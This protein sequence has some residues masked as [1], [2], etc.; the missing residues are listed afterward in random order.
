MRSVSFDVPTKKGK[1]SVFFT[2]SLNFKNIKRVLITG[3]RRYRGY[4]SVEKIEETYR[5]AKVKFRRVNSIVESRLSFLNDET[6]NR[7][8]KII[9]ETVVWTT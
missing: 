2:T 5:L 6:S 4:L 1:L 3:D 7:I 8:A 9:G